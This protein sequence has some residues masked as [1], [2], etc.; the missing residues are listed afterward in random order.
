MLLFHAVAKYWSEII[1]PN[2]EKTLEKNEVIPVRI[3][4]NYFPFP[5]REKVINRQR[6]EKK[7]S[8]PGKG[9]FFSFPGKGKSTKKSVLAFFGLFGLFW[10]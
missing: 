8:L 3:E 5:G 6:E 9:K 7:F 10:P 1:L 2:H 4:Q